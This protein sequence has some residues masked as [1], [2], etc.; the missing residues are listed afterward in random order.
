M[1]SFYDIKLRPGTREERVKLTGGLSDLSSRV[2]GV[3][4]FAQ[5]KIGIDSLAIHVGVNDVPL[6]QLRYTAA[7]EVL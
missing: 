7:H 4:S 5:I 2:A 1:C 6:V 3:V